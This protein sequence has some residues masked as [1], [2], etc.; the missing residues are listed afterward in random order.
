MVRHIVPATLLVRV[1]CFMK[2]LYKAVEEPNTRPIILLMTNGLYRRR[3]RRH[4]HA[5]R[6][7]EKRKTWSFVTKERQ[8]KTFARKRG[9]TYEV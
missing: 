3:R 4:G 9:N 1:Q 6:R 7:K 5:S 8:F 2:W